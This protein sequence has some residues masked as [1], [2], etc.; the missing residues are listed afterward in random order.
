ML[1]GHLAPVS[2]RDE[3]SAMLASPALDDVVVALSPSPRRFGFDRADPKFTAPKAR[4]D[5]VRRDQLLARLER[6]RC[7]PLIL[8]TAPAGYGK[9]TLLAQWAAESSRPFAWV[10]LD[11][12]DDDAGTLAASISKA[13]D[14]VEVEPGLGGSF[15]LVLDDAHV[16]RP[17]V[18]KAAVLRILDWLPERS[19]LSVAS[20]REPALPLGRMRA[21]R[22]LLEFS[23][24]DLSMSAIEAGS[25]LA[26]AGLDPELRP[27][28]TL[29]RRSEG[30]PVALELATISWTPHL[31]AAEPTQL[32]GDDH[33]ISEYFR[34]ELL[35]SLPP[36]TRRFLMRSSVLDYL[37]GP[38]CDAVLG[39]TRSAH[40]LAKLARTNLPLRP[41]DSSHDSFRLHGLFREMLQTELRR[42]EPELLPILYRRASEWYAHA[43]DIVWA[44]DHARNADDL[45]RVG[46][47]LWRHM[48][49]FLGEGRNGVVQ[50][51]LHG[52]DAERA[53]GCHEL[54]LA[55][56]HSGLALGSATLAEQWA[57]SAAVCMSETTENATT[58]ARAGVLLVEAWAARSGA[59][60]MGEVAARA[61]DLLPDDD[62][63]RA[64]CC[65]L[66]GSAALLIGDRRE[67]ERLLEEGA[68]RGDQ[69]A[70]DAAS[71]CLAQLSVCAA[72]RD[73]PLVASDFARSARSMIT[74]HGLSTTPAS[75]LVFAVCAA[76][77]MREGRVDEAKAAASE[78]R[79][80]LAQIDD[81]LAWLSAET[82]ILVA[83]VSLG[84]GHVA[85]ARELLADASRLARRT[86]DVVIFQR[87]FDDAWGQFDER[88][89]TTLAGMGSLTTAE[90]RVLRF[91]PTHYPFHEIAQRLHVSSNTVKTHV[92]AVYRKLDASSRSEA[93]A[94]ATRAGLLGG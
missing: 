12:A 49:R 81:S 41:V 44:I 50:G 13:L 64:S 84:L 20:R 73:D 86:T 79:D 10:T 23:S 14:N 62:P 76:S 15:V 5:S 26:Q 47:L 53:A 61:Y 11:H 48:R 89:E 6:E 1:V 29:V 52:V 43:G 75:A 65:F 94:T 31:G 33:V 72:E 37:S 91:L 90:L 87:W 77:A 22:L 30:W 70:P 85:R 3:A 24:V 45:G 35:A 18:L 28:Q 58:S 38:V 19:Q 4:D 92:H 59:K 36:A 66:R 57:R 32:R 34:V 68:R 67:A 27:M 46:N 88:A 55:A 7:R 16:V 82:R 71:L 25:L 56:A 42:S 9:T 74:S 78:C 63:W 54:A 17:E 40:I 83:R 21:Q 2:G 60:R 51:W 80:L 8:L 93:V 39:S 69:Q